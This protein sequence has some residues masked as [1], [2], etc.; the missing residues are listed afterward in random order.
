MSMTQSSASDLAAEA[1][2]RPGGLKAALRGTFVGEAWRALKA[3]RK[4]AVL[5]LGP[6]VAR[7][8]AALRADAEAR[9]RALAERNPARARALAGALGPGAAAILT[10]RLDGWAAAAP[11]FDRLAPG[12]ARAAV[13]LRRGAPGPGL[14]LAV[15]AAGRPVDLP[16][17]TAA[18][19]VVYTT[20]FGPGGVL[21]PLG[22]V[23]GVRFLCLS[24]RDDPAE[25][26][27]VV[28]FA[29]PADVDPALAADLCRIRPEVALAAAAPAAEASLYLAPDVLLAGNFATLV[30]RWLAPHALVAW[31]H[32]RAVSWRDLA[33]AAALAAPPERRAAALDQAREC[34]A[35]GLPA[36]AGAIDTRLLWRRHK[37]AAAAALAEAWWRAFARHPGDADLALA[38]ALAAPDAP[39]AP[40]L[41]PAALGTAEHNLYTA[42]S[43]VGLS[44]APRRPAPGR[45]PGSARLKI[46][47][48][49]QRGYEH[50]AST[51][52]R[53]EQLAGLLAERL[54]G[55]YEFSYTAETDGLRDQVVVLTKWALERRRPAEIAALRAKNVA[56]IASWDDKIPLAELAAVVDA[57]MTLSIAQ[58]V[59]LGR[60]FPA[61]PTYFV[62]HH[63]NRLIRPGAPPMD[64]LRAGYFGE[65]FNTVRPDSLAGEI[66]LN[67]IDTTHKAAGPTAWMDALDRYN[68]H[69][70]V[71]QR[72]YFDGAKPFLK[73]FVAA[74]CG[75]VVMVARDDG[76]AAYYLGDDYPFYVRGLDPATLEAD[77]L[78]V[79][80]A[81]GG[82]D[83]R[84]AE[85]IM[86]QVAA[87][88]A[89]DVVCAQ[90]AAMI[91]AI[92]G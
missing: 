34:E 43:P 2:A 54:G 17:E 33:E 63:V 22:P 1:S 81:F 67:G 87:R 40:R 35:A 91:E 51:L 46:A 32:P 11:L 49:H 75:A 59:D 66:A 84:M 18:G 38:R 76:D 72:H 83:W 69:W 9:L 70:I 88:S 3:R 30:T 31:R 24:D 23:P 29:P 20:R 86:R 57:Q 6:E 77:W 58:A 7:R 12:D 92:T 53:A 62:T 26:W 52:L 39:A 90:F 21:A 85:A 45:R 74:R 14:A 48:V 89:D 65:L 82:P 37:T 60:R 36:E 25:G 50:Y 15:P 8:R 64:R 42:V 27:E 47:I 13:L 68:L 56:V 78:R 80:S 61:T 71:R 4:E 5:R 73:C 55:R 44:P 16:A 79:A 28:R 10:A 19:L 41:L